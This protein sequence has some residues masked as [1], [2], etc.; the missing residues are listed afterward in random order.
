[1]AS[2]HH[3][4]LLVLST[5][6]FLFISISTQNPE[7]IVLPVLKDIR[8]GQYI[9]SLYQ[10]T[11]PVLSELVV[12]I[13]SR[14]L[15]VDCENNY[16]S[17]S[18]HPAQ[19]NSSQCSLAD[20]TTCRTCT[21]PPSPGCN[22]NTCGL[23]PENSI[24]GLSTEGDLIDDVVTFRS[25]D[26]TDATVSEF[27]FPCG[28]TSLLQGLAYG[29]EGM[30]GFG[31]RSMI[32]IPYQLSS[33]FNIKPQFALC[34]SPSS[35]F[36]GFIFVGNSGN[37]NLGP[38]IDV[39]SILMRTP[40]V[41]NP[42]NAQG[43]ASS[44]YFIGV[45]SIKID[46]IQVKVNTSLLDIDDQGV[47]G[48]KISTVTAFTTMETSI[49]KAVT[50]AFIKAAKAKKM[51]RV[52]PVKPFKACF[53]TGSINSTSAGPDVPIV[54]LVLGREDV[55]WRMF[56]AN[57]MVEVK[58]RKALCLGLVDGGSSP[59]TSVVIG[60]KQLEN[61]FLEFDLSTSVLGFSSSLLQRNTT[62]AN[63]NTKGIWP[64]LKSSY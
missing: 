2:Q 6:L 3:Q 62:C 37:Y 57:S 24:T 61:I 34:L 14:Y 15:W 41:T 31:R 49:Y 18:Y 32:S 35:F 21:G 50:L 17:S 7:T 59:R 47:G 36:N 20:A 38:G 64:E 45:S 46:G 11:P 44:E 30:A 23:F 9:T 27:L 33:V 42:V 1:M 10:G 60:G 26:G 22:N 63:F 25:I 58:W 4:Q 54:D 16:N 52:A 43:E 29:V 51:K 53:S 40:L 39:S 12:D 28:S 56:G 19:C 5:F 48:T 8:N 13:G 55:Y